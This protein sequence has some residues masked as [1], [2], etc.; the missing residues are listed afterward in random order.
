M[1]QGAEPIYD[2]IPGR[3]ISKW[4]SH[5]SVGTSVNLQVPRSEERRVGKECA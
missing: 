3:E 1:F 4:F 2:I 5:Q